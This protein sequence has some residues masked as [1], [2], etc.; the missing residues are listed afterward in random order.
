MCSQAFIMFENLNKRKFGKTLN[1][2]IVDG[3]ILNTHIYLLVALNCMFPEMATR[4]AKTNPNA[5]SDKI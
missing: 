3:K 4:T 5:K 2:I 1:D